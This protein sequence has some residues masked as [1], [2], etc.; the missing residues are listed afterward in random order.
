MS[1]LTWDTLCATDLTTL[2][3]KVWYP[4]YDVF[5]KRGTNVRRTIYCLPLVELLFAGK[6]PQQAKCSKGRKTSLNKKYLYF[7]DYWL[8]L[9]NPARYLPNTPAIYRYLPTL[10]LATISNVPGTRHMKKYRTGPANG[11]GEPNML[12]PPVKGSGRSERCF[13]FEW[14]P[15]H[16]PIEFVSIHLWNWR[17]LLHRDCLAC[18]FTT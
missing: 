14:F 2:N 6:S 11:F 17:I 4:P 13:L 15:T 16:F 12:Y 1:V 18:F 9:G 7:S 5:L 8:Q 10:L 3:C